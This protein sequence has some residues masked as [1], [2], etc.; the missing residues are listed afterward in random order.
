[1]PSVSDAHLADLLLLAA[2]AD[3]RLLPDHHLM[4]RLADELLAR[5]PLWWLE[6]CCEEGR[7][8]TCLMALR[9]CPQ[10]PPDEPA[11]YCQVCDTHWEPELECL[12]AGGGR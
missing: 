5:R 6:R 3:G 9:A 10:C 7:C 4:A 11:L 2:R 12:T 1:M 8:P